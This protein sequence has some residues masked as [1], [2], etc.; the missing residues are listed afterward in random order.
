MDDFVK[1]HQEYRKTNIITTQFAM[2]FELTKCDVEWLSKD[3][4]LIYESIKKFSEKVYN[5]W[6]RDYYIKAETRGHEA[7]H[8]GIKLMLWGMCGRIAVTLEDQEGYSVTLYGLEERDG[9][10]LHG[11][12]ATAANAKFMLDVVTAT[13]ETFKELMGTNKKVTMFP[14]LTPEE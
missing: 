6:L 9:M 14:G 2:Y 11:I 7:I 4:D 5:T 3:F 13:N 8:E 10:S 12:T 1:L